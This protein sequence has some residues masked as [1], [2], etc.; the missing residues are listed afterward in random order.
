VLANEEA[1]ADSFATLWFAVRQPDDA[2]RVVMARVRSWLI[3]DSEV[4]PAA[5]DFKG[6]HLLDIRR[7]YQAAC[8]LY[9]A[10]PSRWT[11]AVAWLDFN[12][13]DL[14]DC[15]DT[16]PD[17][18]EG[19]QA[20]LAPHWLPE[21]RSS[22]KVEVI[23][24]EGVLREDMIAA[25]VVDEVARIAARFDWPHP[26]TLHFDACDSGARWS[27]QSRTI[28]LCDSYVARFVNQG[29]ALE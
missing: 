25:G 7:A 6:E 17:Q 14:D 18:I 23:Y 15:S 28:L 10:D 27:R 20:V 2:E 13:G 12:Q 5:Y 26:V 11:Q 8:L 9:G 24:G 3:E 22:R 1:M 4:D 21:G 16:A 29:R 19:W